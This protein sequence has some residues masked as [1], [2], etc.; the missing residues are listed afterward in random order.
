MVEA[1]SQHDYPVA[2]ASFLV[3]AVVVVVLNMLTDL[4]YGWLD[5]RIQLAS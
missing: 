3:L 5:P 4:L 2:L 1:A